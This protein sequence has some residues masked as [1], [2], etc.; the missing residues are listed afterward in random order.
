M[1]AERVYPAPW[2]APSFVAPT[3]T[4]RVEPWATEYDEVSREHPDF[5]ADFSECGEPDPEFYQSTPRLMAL[6]DRLEALR[7]KAFREVANPDYDAE[8][9]AS[10]REQQ[11]RRGNQT[12]IRVG[13]SWNP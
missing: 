13:Q 11:R 8:Q 1:M 10:W 2:A 4:E 9:A 12:R 6:D 7:A 3:I 5:Y